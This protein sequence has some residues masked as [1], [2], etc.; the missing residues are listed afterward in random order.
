M[1]FDSMSQEMENLDRLNMKRMIL[2]IPGEQ[3]ASDYIRMMQPE[4]HSYL[5]G[6]FLTIGAYLHSH[7]GLN[8]NVNDFTLLRN[9]DNGT[10]L[11]QTHRDKQSICTCRQK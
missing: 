8:Y 3:K 1:T 10:G 2:N 7:L 5:E 11:Q 6:S 4:I 9:G